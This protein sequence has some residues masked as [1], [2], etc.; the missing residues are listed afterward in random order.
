[1]QTFR[2][3]MVLGVGTT[4]TLGS[5]PCAF[6]T[7][8]ER[9]ASPRTLLPQSQQSTSR[10][11]LFL[12]S[13]PPV[14]SASAATKSG[15]RGSLQ[16]RSKPSIN[17]S[18]GN[19]PGPQL[20]PLEPSS[21]T[22]APTPT[23]PSPT[24]S[25]APP[26]APTPPAPTAPPTPSPTPPPIAPTPASPEDLNLNRLNP[27]PDLLQLPTEPSQV[28]LQPNQPITLQQALEL[29]RRNNRDLQVAEVTL[30]R[31]RSALRESQA[32]LYPTADADAGL[33]FSRTDRAVPENPLA[34]PG[35]SPNVTRADGSRLLTGTVTARYDVYTSGRRTALIRAAEE[36]VRFNELDVE[37]LTE[38]L[39]L[40]VANDYYDVQQADQDVLISRAAVDNAQASVNDAQALERAGLGTR[41]DVLQAQVELANSTQDL[42]DA[43]SRQQTSRRQLANR[44][45]LGF[46]AGVS[47]ADPVQKAPDWGRSLE[48]SIVLAFQNRAELL[49]QIAQR[50]ISEQQRR[51]ALAD[52][53]PQLS[54]IGRYRVT[55]L[56]GD[57]VGPLNDFSVGPQVTLSLFDG[58]AARARAAQQEAN[59]RIAE[60]NFANQRN[61]IRFAV[62]QAYNNLGSSFDNIRTSSAAVAQARESLR[63]A[64]LRFQAGVGIQSDVLD[65][66]AALAQAEGNRVQAILG[67]N[68]SLVTLQREVSNLQTGAP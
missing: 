40:D 11:S 54:L 29:A 36:Q 12:A 17:L 47:A 62:E 25:P 61:L 8:S 15:S 43:L 38:Q 60:T 46:T 1:M 39:R 10:L 63:L 42:T 3:L 19:A 2:Y 68:R 33:T 59:A 35:T 16:G 51:V 6:G 55:Q 14:K 23:T 57:G 53:G 27:S 28:Q 37:R 34:P 30:R 32:A 52:L 67:Y 21:P 48:D 4:L 41:F 65:A 24:P 44:L 22:P 26:P 66:V 7:T 18:Q 31:A 49:Q 45:S 58:G 20:P 50:N 64:R 56:T 5:V 9:I 13:V